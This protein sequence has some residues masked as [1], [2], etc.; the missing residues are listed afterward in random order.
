M[1]DTNVTNTP[2]GLILLGGGVVLRMD[3]RM[4]LGF[5]TSGAGSKYKRTDVYY[6]NLS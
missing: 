3:P 4:E 1:T 6:D 5:F 2:A